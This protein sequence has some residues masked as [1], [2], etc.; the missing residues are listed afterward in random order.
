[1]GEQEQSVYGCR[2]GVSGCHQLHYRTS[3]GITECLI[4]QSIEIKSTGG[5]IP[6]VVVVVSGS[7]CP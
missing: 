4:G 3:G 6:A 7:V 2:M 1:M 5:H